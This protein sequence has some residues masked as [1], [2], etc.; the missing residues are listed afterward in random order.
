MVRGQ[1][2]CV[3]DVLGACLVPV[4][5]GM[6]HLGSVAYLK[7]FTSLKAALPEMIIV[8]FMGT[9]ASYM[10]GHCHKKSKSGY[11]LF[12]LLF[13]FYLCTCHGEAMNM[14]PS[15]VAFN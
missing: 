9:L 1:D 14:K 8:F 5:D 6:G 10:K 15:P 4:V 7:A 3:L 11:L 13:L 2:L 12:L